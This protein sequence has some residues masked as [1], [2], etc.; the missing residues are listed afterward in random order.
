MLRS[1]TIGLVLLFNLC[2]CGLSYG[3]SKSE[4]REK[5]EELEGQLQKKKEQIGVQ[6]D[7]LLA[8]R[9]RNLQ[10][11]LLVHALRDSVQEQALALTQREQVRQLDSVDKASVAKVYAAQ[12]KYFEASTSTVAARLDKQKYFEEQQLTN[13]LKF[14]AFQT[15]FMETCLLEYEVFPNTQS[16]SGYFKSE[17]VPDFGEV[18]FHIEEVSGTYVQ[19]EGVIELHITEIGGKATEVEVVHNQERPYKSEVHYKTI[20]SPR[21]YTKEVPLPEMSVSEC[22]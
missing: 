6:Q 11:K 14:D 10:L 17:Y 8:L 19:K 21:L 1:K 4:L 12:K 20:G 22:D 18:E 9:E 5:V 15:L 16:F 3:Q 2:W 7:S 13:C